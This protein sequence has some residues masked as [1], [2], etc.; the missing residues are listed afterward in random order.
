MLPKI[1]VT[2]TMDNRDTAYADFAIESVEATR[3]YTVYPGYPVQDQQ[4][5]VS[6]VSN[7]NYRHSDRVQL[8]IRVRTHD[9]R[10]FST[11]AWFY[12]LKVNDIVFDGRRII[13]RAPR[14]YKEVAQYDTLA[15]SYGDLIKTPPNNKGD[16]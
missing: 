1:L 13:V 2:Y 8:N 3:T 4:E 14:W 10:T 16:Y 6:N 9:L 5:L 11:Q 7:Y 15:I 12:H